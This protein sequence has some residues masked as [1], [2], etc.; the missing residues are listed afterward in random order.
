MGG[1]Q[2]RE[3][4]TYG[5]SQSQLLLSLGAQGQVSR[6]GGYTQSLGSPEFSQADILS[7]GGGG[8]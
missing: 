3:M 1:P 5:L 2:E 7:Q 4:V 6:A 8:G